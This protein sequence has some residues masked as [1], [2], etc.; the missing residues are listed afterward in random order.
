MVSFSTISVYLAFSDNT[1]ITGSFILLKLLNLLVRDEV[2]ILAAN[3]HSFLVNSLGGIGMLSEEVH[4]KSQRVGARA[5]A[6]LKSRGLHAR[7]TRIA[8]RKECDGFIQ[9]LL[10]RK[11]VFLAKLLLAKH[12]IQQTL[13]LAF[14][15]SDDRQPTHT[16]KRPLFACQTSFACWIL[17][18]K[19]PLQD[20]TSRIRSK[21]KPHRRNSCI[22][23][24]LCIVKHNRPHELW[25]S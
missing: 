23:L 21:G 3:G 16:L 15:S 4:S 14:A 2:K 25:C 22:K 6:G 24:L 20:A 9:D 17:T 8:N 19:R 10:I 13:G 12:G 18:R 1:K 5:K 11:A 7:F